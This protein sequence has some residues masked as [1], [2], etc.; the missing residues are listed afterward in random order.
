MKK[1]FGKNQVIISALAI[2]IAVAGY[3]SITQD[4]A[5]KTANITNDGESAQK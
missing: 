1:I 4:K 3:L 2:M 5:Q